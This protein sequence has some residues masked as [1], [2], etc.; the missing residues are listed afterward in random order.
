MGQ[1][2]IF[3]VIGLSPD[4]RAKASVNIDNGDQRS[5]LKVFPFP[6]YLT[7]NSARSP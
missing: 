1:R 7:L 2:N 6:R 5:V 4:Y 3:E